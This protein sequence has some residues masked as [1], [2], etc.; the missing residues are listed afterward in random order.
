M[1]LEITPE[2][3]EI[4]IREA[5]RRGITAAEVALDSLRARFRPAEISDARDKFEPR[6]LVEF[7]GDLVGTLDSGKSREGGARLSENTGDRLRA[8]LIEKQQRERARRK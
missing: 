2:L 8:I 6:N 1:T 7:L 3:E 5:E 4:L